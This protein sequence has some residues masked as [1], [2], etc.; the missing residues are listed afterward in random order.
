MHTDVPYIKSLKAQDPKV[1]KDW[2]LQ[3]F[4]A[5]MRQAS[6]FFSEEAEQMTAVHNAQLKALKNLAQFKPET[7]MEAWLA[8]ILRNELIDLYRRQHKWRWLSFEAKHEVALEPDFDRQM[9]EELELQK[10][11]AVLSN[12]SPTTRFVFSFYVYEQQ[13]PQEIASALK[14]NIQTVRWHLK[15]AKHI[16]KNQLSHD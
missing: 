10:V 7:S 3:T 2:Y 6:R 13:K 11:E 12:L 14:M 15:T 1:L 4:P 16:L 9:D 5:L 8:V